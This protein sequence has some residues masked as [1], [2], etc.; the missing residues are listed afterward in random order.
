MKC[1]ILRN[2]KEGRGKLMIGIFSDKQT[3]EAERKI[4]VHLAST[5]V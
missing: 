5:L 4:L 1:G 3:F 2:G